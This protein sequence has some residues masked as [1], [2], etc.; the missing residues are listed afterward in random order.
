MDGFDEYQKSIPIHVEFHIAKWHTNHI[1]KGY[2]AR[3]FYFKR[4]IPEPI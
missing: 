2:L 4:A 3:K 1:L